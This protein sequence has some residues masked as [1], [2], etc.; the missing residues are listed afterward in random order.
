MSTRLS[1]LV[2]LIIA[3]ILEARSA[4]KQAALDRHVVANLLSALA[5]V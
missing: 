5:E 4:R 3:R 2:R 1:Q